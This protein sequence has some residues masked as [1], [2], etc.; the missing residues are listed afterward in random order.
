VTPD[1]GGAVN[2]Q[3]DSTM[4][5]TGLVAMLNMQIGEIAF[6]GI[7]SGLYGVLVFVLL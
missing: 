5:A 3:L 4:P 7:G 2:A 6:G 1:A